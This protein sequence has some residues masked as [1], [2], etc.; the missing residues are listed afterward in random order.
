MTVQ[1]IVHNYCK[2]IEIRPLNNF[3]VG[4]FMRFYLK[5]FKSDPVLTLFIYNYK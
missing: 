4:Y 1:I 3:F 5:L 2:I